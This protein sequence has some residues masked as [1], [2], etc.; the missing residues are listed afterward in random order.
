[1][2]IRRKNLKILRQWHIEQHIFL[3][4]YCD[5]DTLDRFRPLMIN[6]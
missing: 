3:K 2:H 1:M 5:G 4:K 6:L